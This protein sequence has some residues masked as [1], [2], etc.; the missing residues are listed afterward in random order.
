VLIP[1]LTAVAS[2]AE[3]AGRATIV[4][5]QPDLPAAEVRQKAEK[6]VGSGALHASWADM[7]FPASAFGKQDE[8]RLA[9]VERAVGDARKRW[10]EFDAESEITAGLG[11]AISA[12]DVLRDDADRKLLAS[13]LLLQ[14]AA[15]LRL[16]PA[17]QFAT[18][19]AVGPYRL[20]VGSTPA[21]RPFLDALSLEPDATWTRED[22]LDG[23]AFDRLGTDR[24]AAAGQARA[25]LQVDALPAGVTLVVDGRPLDAAAT[26]LE[27]PAGRHYIHALVG[28]AIAG[29]RILDAG[30]GANVPFEPVVSRGELD[31]ARARVLEG[32]KDL[33]ED[34]ATAATAI[35]NRGGVLT[36][37]F[38]AT[39]DDKGRVE[40]L[41]FTGGA[42]FKKE[43][44]V[45]F[46]L[47]G[48]VGGAV[49]NSPAFVDA[50]GTPTTTFGV[51]GNL[52]AELGIY[53]LAIY[54]GGTMYL[55][56]LQRM[57]YATGS[58][59]AVDE[60]VDTNASFS[61]YGGLGVYLPRPRSRSV[62]VLL[63]AHYGWVSPGTMGFG[64]RLSFGIPS[65][66]DT[67]FRIEL[68]GV[69]GTQMKG[70]PA[71]GEPSL[72]A[73]VRL[74]FGRKL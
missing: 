61:P 57:R 30:A 69:R 72:Y 11:A 63:G 44:P 58:D 42:A 73:G 66:N 4:W 60:N 37:T 27:L 59:P 64:G 33:P 28:G 34:I 50:V 24:D 1:L 65:G 19:D 21:V 20:F 70:F 15:A 51:G 55:T 68:D 39:L 25:V 53:N 48:S 52:G 12:I 74:G 3:G 9:A 6:I 7:A 10:D 14:G 54:T 47:A 40:V 35:G 5:M 18:A 32:S 2:A 31:E 46:I 29:R 43:A 45:T 23:D 41:P 22:V 36:P 56:P 8:T 71:E 38:V 49:V 17:N 13:A 67:W 62:L 26:T 16:V